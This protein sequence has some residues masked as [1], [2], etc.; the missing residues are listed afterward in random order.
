MFGPGSQSSTSPS[1]S[2]AVP[3]GPSLIPSFDSS[4]VGTNGP[5]PAIP[6]V[7]QESTK[8]LA[9]LFDLS[10]ELSVLGLKSRSCK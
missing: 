5:L 8:A 10:S 2:A 9:D 4:V 6:Q 1:V 7:A 3:S